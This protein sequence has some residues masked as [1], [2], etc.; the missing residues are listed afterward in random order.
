MKER[1]GGI[2]YSLYAAESGSKPLGQVD[3]GA[4]QNTTGTASLPTNTWSHLAVT[5]DGA[6]LRL[7]VGGVQVASKGVTG[8]LVAST[9]PLRIGGNGIWGEYFSERSTRCG[10][11]TAR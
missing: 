3:N 1:T 6:T 5:W 10:C 9:A 8:S 11:T 2:L 7:Y 4:E